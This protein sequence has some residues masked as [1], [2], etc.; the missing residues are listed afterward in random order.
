MNA[1]NQL[2]N[3]DEEAAEPT[4]DKWQSRIVLAAASGHVP[5]GEIKGWWIGAGEEERGGVELS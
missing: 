2:N 1:C 3:M 4:A 5:V